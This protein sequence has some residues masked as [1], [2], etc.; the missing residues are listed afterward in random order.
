MAYNVEWLPETESEL[1]VF[2]RRFR[3]AIINKVEHIAQNLPTSLTLRTI[4][5][6]RGQA[7]LGFIGTLFELDVGSGPRVAFRLDEERE[8]LMVYLVGNHD[9]CRDNYL[10]AAEDRL[11]G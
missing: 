9:Y 5:R 11:E 1:R 7:A 2:D 6:I 3:K 4:Q 10:R 8:L